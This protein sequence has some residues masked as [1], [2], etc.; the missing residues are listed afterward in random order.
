MRT[1]KRSK[2]VAVDTS[3]SA[4]SPIEWRI[5]VMRHPDGLF[6]HLP[7]GSPSAEDVPTDALRAL[8]AFAVKGLALSGVGE[9]AQIV[10]DEFARHQPDEVTDAQVVEP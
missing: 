2:V 6:G 3:D 5:H 1:E 4:D 10:R 7:G 8:L 9:A